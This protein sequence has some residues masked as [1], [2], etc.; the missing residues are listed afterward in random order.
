MSCIPI[1]DFSLIS[2]CDA[3]K[4][5]KLYSI[6][7]DDGSGDFDVARNSTARYRGADGLIK[8]AA[9]DE[10]RIEFNPDGS[11]KGLLVEPQRTNLALYSEQ[12]DD[13]YWGKTQANVTANT[14]ISPNGQQTADTITAQA[15]QN[16]PRVARTLSLTNNT[17]YVL[18][19]FVKKIDASIIR[20]RVDTSTSI[21]QSSYNIDTL[22]VVN[23]DGTGGSIEQYPNGWVRAS[24]LFNSGSNASTVDIRPI[25]GNVSDG[26]NGFF[27]GKSVIA[28]GAQLEAAP[29]ASSYIKTEASTVTRVADVV[30]KTGASSLIG[31]TEFSAYFDVDVTLNQNRNRRIASIQSDTADNLIFFTITPDDVLRFFLRVNNQSVFNI[32]DFTFQFSGRH[33]ILFT[34]KS[35]QHRIFVNGNLVESNSNSGFLSNIQNIG[36][37][38]RFD[39]S[40]DFLNDHIKAVA[41]LPRAITEAEAIALTS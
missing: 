16:F 24:L 14:S 36:L 13:A 15:G 6:V 4:A 10:P 29:T 41:L 17:N 20:L 37:G 3:T 34:S 8:T 28:W 7:P 38:L 18:S 23:I 27:D 1:Q 40:S 30:S 22:A 11:Y 35:G 2:L 21:I 39:N 12:F 9:I 32:G 26:S 5:G 25:A 33:K 31:Q 19:V